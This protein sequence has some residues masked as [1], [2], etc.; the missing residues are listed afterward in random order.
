MGRVNLGLAALLGLL[1]PSLRKCKD[2]GCL[3]FFLPVSVALPNQLKEGTVQ[4]LNTCSGLLRCVEV[5][6]F[7]AGW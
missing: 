1:G 5:A 3:S 6:L 4:K 7:D 2:E